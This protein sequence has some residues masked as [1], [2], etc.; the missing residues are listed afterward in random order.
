MQALDLQR[1]RQLDRMRRA[2]HVRRRVLLGRRGHI[3]DRR[4]VEEMLD[5]ASEL[6][7][8]LCLDPQQWSAQVPDHRLHALGGGHSQQRS[9]A[10]D[11]IVQPVR[12][13]PRTST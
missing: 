12:S 7:R 11:Q 10:L 13:S 9:P 3:V 2:A 5:L 4:E 6:C 1:S 8:L